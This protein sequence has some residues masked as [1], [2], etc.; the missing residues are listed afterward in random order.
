M[1]KIEN[2]FLWL[3]NPNQ[4]VSLDKDLKCK[5]NKVYS[6]ETCCFLTRSDNAKEVRAR[7]SAA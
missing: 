4:G 1:P 5:G 7:Q 3:N 2:Y 6:L